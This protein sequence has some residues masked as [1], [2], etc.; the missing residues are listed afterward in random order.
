MVSGTLVTDVDIPPADMPLTFYCIEGD[1]I[2]ALLAILSLI[3]TAYITYD[4]R[5]Q[6]RV[7]L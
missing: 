1:T 5:R 3:I 2:W 6:Q 7:T 4:L